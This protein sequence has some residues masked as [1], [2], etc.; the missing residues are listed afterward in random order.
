MSLGPSSS[1]EPAFLAL[2]YELSLSVQAKINQSGIVSVVGILCVTSG[3]LLVA[4]EPTAGGIVMGVGLL[5][6]VVSF[7]VGGL[8]RKSK[9]EPF[10]LVKHRGGFVWLRGAS[11]QQVERYPALPVMSSIFLNQGGLTAIFN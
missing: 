3:V 4:L 8:T 7:I 1:R 6:V 11:Q 10:Q 9:Y 2:L 5:I